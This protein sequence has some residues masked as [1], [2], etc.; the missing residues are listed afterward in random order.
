MYDAPRHAG[1]LYRNILVSCDCLP[2]IASHTRAKNYLC[3]RWPLGRGDAAKIQLK[4]LPKPFIST[5][6]IIISQKDEQDLGTRLSSR[7]C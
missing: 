2:K 3:S 7:S 4:Q 5:S 1:E 6:V